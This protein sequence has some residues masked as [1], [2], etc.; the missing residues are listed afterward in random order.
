MIELEAV[1]S[2]DNASM[3]VKD[4]I[5]NF[6]FSSLDQYGDKKEDILKCLDYALSPFRH[7]GGF[8]LLAKENNRIVGAVVM[9]QTGMEGYIPENILVYIAI[10]SSHRGRGLGKR[11]MKKAIELARGDIALHVEPDNPARYLYEKLGFT[12]KY[13]EM[14]LKKE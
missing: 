11:L 13:L 10:K 12:S 5:A 4:R 6:L 3:L 1:T 2:I 8:V 7:Q 9:N 14:R